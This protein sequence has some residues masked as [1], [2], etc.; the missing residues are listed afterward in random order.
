MNKETFMA[1]DR[2]RG[3]RALPLLSALLLLILGGCGKDHARPGQVLDERP[4]RPP[5]RTTSTTWTA[6]AA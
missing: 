3:L 1:D 5:P 2:V 6:A 4:F